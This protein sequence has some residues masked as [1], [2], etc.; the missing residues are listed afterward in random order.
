MVTAAQKLRSVSIADYLADEIAA[1]EKHEYLGGYVYAK[2][3]GRVAHNRIT[4]N[5]TVALGS[6]L[7]GSPCQPYNSD[8]KVRVQLP[9]HT[10]FYYPD[11]SVVCD[12]NPP[13][14]T[15]QDQP[16]VIV[17]VLSRDT[18]RID[19]TEKKEA[20]LTIPSLQ[21]Y[22]LVEQDSSKVT[23]HRRTEQGFHAEAYEGLAGFIP[24]SGIGIDLAIGNIYNGVKFESEPTSENQS[25]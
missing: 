2:A 20:Y 6:A 25:E 11:V 23:V 16:V 8:M 19:E 7:Q 22:L 1:N 14:D 21:A 18:R 24:L 13:D 12:S 4:T 9:S 10:R 5:I 15:F 17:E 3:G